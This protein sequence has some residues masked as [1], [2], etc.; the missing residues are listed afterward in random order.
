MRSV[1]STFMGHNTYD[2]YLIKNVT[3]LRE[4]IILICENIILIN[5]SSLIRPIVQIK[6]REIV[7]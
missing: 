1:S 3:L 4:S 7:S 6:I 5:I 2:I